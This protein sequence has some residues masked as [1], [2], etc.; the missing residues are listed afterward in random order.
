MVRGE[1][2]LIALIRRILGYVSQKKFLLIFINFIYFCETDSSYLYI[3][4][5]IFNLA[6]FYNNNV[7][8]L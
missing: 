8:K 5:K 4:H 7:L 6:C 3:V 2:L 1:I